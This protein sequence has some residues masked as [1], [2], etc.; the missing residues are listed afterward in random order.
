MNGNHFNWKSNE[1]ETGIY[2]RGKGERH[3]QQPPPANG[4]GGECS[5]EEKEAKSSTSVYIC[6]P[7]NKVAV[8][9]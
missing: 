4:G 9:P 6:H 3:Q 1:H 2:C 7:L 5:E 8:L